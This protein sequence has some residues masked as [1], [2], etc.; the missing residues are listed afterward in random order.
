MK[1]AFVAGSMLGIL[2]V[3]GWS[4]EAHAA[5]YGL[6]GK[7]IKIEA[8]PG[9]FTVQDT[10][11]QQAGHILFINR[12]PGGVSVSFGND[13]SRTN[14]SSI[15]QGTIFLNEYPFGDASWNAV[16][17]DV[18]E[19]FAP[20]GVTVTDVDP[21]NVPHDE[22]YVCGSDTAAGF[23]PAAGVA[24]FSCGVIPNAVTFVFP[25]TIGDDIRFTAETVAQE[26][27]H[28]W[29]LD[30]L[31]EC[32]DVMTYLEGCGDK[33]FVVGDQQ[34]GE[35]EP[36]ACDCGGN[37]QNSGQLLI[38]LFGDG[39]P[40]T[41]APVVSVV[42]PVDGDSFDLG[43]SFDVLLEANDDTGVT[44]VALYLDGAMMATD[45]MTPF[46][47]WGVNDLPAGEHDLYV[48]ASDIAGNIATSNVVTVWVGD[49][50]PPDGSSMDDGGDDRGD[51]DD[52][53]DGRGD[54]DDDDD[55]DDDAGSGGGLP[56]FPGL[57]EQREDDGCGCTTSPNG[58][59]T[60][61]WLA[62]LLALGL[63]RRRSA[64]V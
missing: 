17:A 25:E 44:Q 23:A 50:A 14:Q 24:P 46:E 63:V 57:M 42:A 20:Y 6:H 3:S 26:A 62:I 51:D 36:R 45:T 43:A 18:K 34:C 7:K 15:V 53:D 41:S 8:P 38:D 55:D 47:G 56:Y 49:G 30:H 37:T 39:A 1:R 10:Q 22:V 4:P 40:D 58:S 64:L 21:G 61:G 59:N 33:G 52:D 12:C 28:A 54:D 11:T 16:M 27:G 2:A 60:L 9:G 48:E 32:T 13:D 35:Y 29:G 31:F 19:I 5:P